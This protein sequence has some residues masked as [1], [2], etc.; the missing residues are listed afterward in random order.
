[1]NPVDAIIL[2]VLANG[3][4]PADERD[5]GAAEVDAGRKLAEKMAAGVNFALYARGLAAAVRSAK[6][7]FG[8]QVPDLCP[9]EAHE[10]VGALKQEEPAFYKQLRMDVAALYLSDS[11]VWE[12]IGFPG[13]SAEQG[14]Y[15]DFAEEQGD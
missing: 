15:P 1:M 12:R 4:I 10:L 5:A 6:Y 9:A 7:L 8:K 14:G 3:I 11:G 13:P 2:A